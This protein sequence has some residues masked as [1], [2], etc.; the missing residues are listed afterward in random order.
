MGVDGQ[1]ADDKEGEEAGKEWLTRPNSRTAY[2]PCMPP[3]YSGNTSFQGG[4]EIAGFG[5][6]ES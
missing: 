6:K 3:L 1:I 2:C 4:K 5:V